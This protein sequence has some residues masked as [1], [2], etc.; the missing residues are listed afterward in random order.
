MSDT[1][2]EPKGFFQTTIR[3]LAE[4]AMQ[5]THHDIDH[6]EPEAIHE[7]QA[8]ERAFTNILRGKLATRRTPETK[9]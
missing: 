9:P 2:R 6:S 1:L 5:I 4:K 3:Q 7:I 8:M